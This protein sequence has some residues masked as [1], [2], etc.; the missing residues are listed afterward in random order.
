MDDP[1]AQ[2]RPGF[3]GGGELW[4]LFSNAI[5]RAWWYVFA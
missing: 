2:G 3:A 5:M 1:H 4:G